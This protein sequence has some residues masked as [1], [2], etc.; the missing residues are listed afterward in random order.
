M[1]MLLF[2]YVFAM[3]LT[4]A[5]GGFKETNGCADAPDLCE[6]WGGLFVSMLSLFKAIAGGISWHEILVPLQKNL[7]ATWVM[8][9]LFYVVF[10]YFA[11]LNVITGVFC[12]SAI[13]SA[14][15]DQ[16]MVMHEAHVA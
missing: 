14:K 8:V 6:Y 16:E 7:D 4:Q 9:F 13:Q 2:I 3:I 5:V 10:L 15:S 1:G 12:E 11:V